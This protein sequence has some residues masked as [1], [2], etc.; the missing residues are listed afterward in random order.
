MVTLEDMLAISML[1]SRVLLA[2]TMTF[3]IIALGLA[4][5]GLYST[6]FYAV[7]QRRTE[8]GIRIALGARRGHL[9]RMV[10]R[11]TGYI[12]LAGAGAGLVAAAILLPAAAA[13]FFGIDGADPGVLFVVAVASTAV[14]LTTTYLVIRPWGRVGAL[15]LIRSPR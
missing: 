13:L 4:V 11:Q 10:L 5:F 8:I 1:L 6:V 14:T 9:F 12:A 7:Q 15:E 2:A 3:A